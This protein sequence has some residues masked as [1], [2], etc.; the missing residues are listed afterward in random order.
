MKELVILLCLTSQHA[1]GHVISS[2]THKEHKVHNIVLY[3][4]K[5]SWCKT[6]PIKQV[7][8]HPGCKSVEIDNNVCVGACFSYSIPR[9]EPETQGEVLP[10]CDSC[11]PS[12]IK[13]KHVTL[14]CPDSD[15]EEDNVMTKRVEMIDGCACTSCTE[16][17]SKSPQSTVTTSAST[18]DVP[19]LMSL[20]LE[21]H[22]RQSKQDPA[23]QSK[24]DPA[25]QYK[26]DP[27]GESRQDHADQ[28]KQDQPVTAS[29]ETGV[30]DSE[31]HKTDE[32]D[33]ST[34]LGKSETD[35]VHTEKLKSTLSS[36][37]HA[38][39]QNHSRHHRVPGPHHSMVYPAYSIDIAEEL[40]EKSEKT[41]TKASGSEVS[42]T[43]ND[44]QPHFRP[45]EGIEINLQDNLIFSPPEDKSLKD[46]P[47]SNVEEHR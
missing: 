2:V 21:T 4:D 43:T 20:M 39:A 41:K 38:H 34:F 9:T 1:I 47:D 33:P 8:T 7:I 15:Y 17:H 11:Q 42:T 28:S 10:Y 44:Q 14:E 40:Y 3:P 19:E 26:Q 37:E 5:H 31:D 16:M 45:H 27:A 18:L 13:W 35:R 29:L 30:T 12:H 23:S 46:K 24:Q 32:L 22:T 6:T 25:S 36:L